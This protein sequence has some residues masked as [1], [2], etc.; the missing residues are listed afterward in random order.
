MPTAGPIRRVRSSGQPH[1]VRA[2][3]LGVCDGLQP[4]MLTAADRSAGRLVRPAPRAVG[5]VVA[6]RCPHSRDFNLNARLSWSRL[7]PTPRPTTFSA[8]V[9]RAGATRSRQTR[10][11]RGRHRRGVD[12]AFD[13]P[14]VVSDS[15]ARSCSRPTGR[16][17]SGAADRTR[18]DRADLEGRASRTPERRAADE[19]VHGRARRSPRSSEY[20]PRPRTSLP[21]ASHQ[22]LAAAYDRG[23][24]SP[25]CPI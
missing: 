25:S 6:E 24:E 23:L 21:L 11:R 5:E 22:R 14:L 15:R 8:G 3:Q 12:S 4:D 10:L 16:R 20:L 9:R 7:S 19:A 17:L 13:A 18:Q 2:R 1:P